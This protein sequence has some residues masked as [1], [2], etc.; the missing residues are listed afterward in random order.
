[1]TYIMA[2]NNRLTCINKHEDMINYNFVMLLYIQMIQ[3]ISL[4]SLFGIS[5]EISN[6]IEIVS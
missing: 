6:H 5:L 2:Y 1:M 4:L 3:S